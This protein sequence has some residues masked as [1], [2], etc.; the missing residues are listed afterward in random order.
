MHIQITHA[1]CTL[2]AHSLQHFRP[3][4]WGIKRIQAS[5]ILH[6]CNLLL[7]GDGKTVY[8]IA[9][10]TYGLVVD[11]CLYFLVYGW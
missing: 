3:S 4:M 9:V 10:R 2:E 5:G 1:Q 8:S 11:A 7:K 6:P